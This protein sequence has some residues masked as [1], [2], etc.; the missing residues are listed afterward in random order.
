M[1]SLAKVMYGHGLTSYR[2]R[3]IPKARMSSILTDPFYY[4]A[5]TWK[6]VLYAGIHE[7]V[8]SKEL[9]EKAQR[10]FRQR[11]RGQA[12]YKVAFPF[13]GMMRCAECGGAI[14]AEA[15]ERTQKNG[16]FHTW[17]YYRCTKKSGTTKC[18]Q[19]FIREEALCVEMAERLR[20]I[21]LPENELW[22]LP[23]LRQLDQW[24]SEEALS[25]SEESAK[26]ES[27]LEEIAAKLRRLDDLHVDGEVDRADYTARK[28]KLVNAKLALEARL[29]KIA[30]QGVKHWLEPLREL[31]NAVREPNLPTAGSD[32]VE[33]R[34]LVA[35]VGSNFQLESRNLVLDW[36]PPYALL[37]ERGGCI[38]WSGRRDSNSRPLAPKASALTGLRYCPRGHYSLQARSGWGLTREPTDLRPTPS[39]IHTA[40]WAG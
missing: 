35:E 18:Q 2:E 27:G 28:R 1:I 29:E 26:L 31:I 22:L 11:G 5:F 16:N 33:L 10:V 38:E 3:L 25:E 34:D 12:H 30:R 21:A 40:G 7:P 9:W 39:P 32:L 8:V 19:P 15:K 13:V 14:T 23:M 17:R 4:G 20:E 24:E 36:N 6:N 37:A